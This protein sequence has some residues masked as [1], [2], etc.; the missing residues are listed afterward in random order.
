MNIQPSPLSVPPWSIRVLT[1]WTPLRGASD[2]GGHGQFVHSQRGPDVVRNQSFLQLVP[3]RSARLCDLKRDQL[4]PR[5]VNLEQEVTAGRTVVQYSL[6]PAREG[7][8][9]VLSKVRQDEVVVVQDQTTELEDDSDV[10]I[11]FGG[12]FVVWFVLAGPRRSVAAATQ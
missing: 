11:L 1:P 12:R 6:D 5:Y 9:E 4:R 10:C 7:L 8:V 3:Q 2:V